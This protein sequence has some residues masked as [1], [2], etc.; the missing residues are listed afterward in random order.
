MPSIEDFDLLIRLLHLIGLDSHVDRGEP[1][2]LVEYP[3]YESAGTSVL[4]FLV[5]KRGQ[6]EE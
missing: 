2:R 4:C 5:E 1:I 6:S 3:V